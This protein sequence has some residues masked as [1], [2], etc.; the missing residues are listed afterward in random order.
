MFVHAKNYSQLPC[1][2]KA[3]YFNGACFIYRKS[4][5]KVCRELIPFV[6]PI[7]AI[8]VFSKP[9]RD[10][11]II[12]GK[13]KQAYFCGQPQTQTIAKNFSKTRIRKK[14]NDF[15]RHCFPS[16]K[17][18]LRK[19]CKK[20]ARKHNFCCK[21]T[22]INVSYYTN[23]LKGVL[24]MLSKKLIS[25]VL[26]TALTTGG[27]FAELYE[28]KTVYN[29]M[30]L[31]NG[32][33][34]EVSSSIVSGAGLRIL[35][36]L[37][38]VY[39]Y[40]NN[41]TA[42]ALNQLAESL[43][44]SFKGSK[45]V[46]VENIKRHVQGKHH[47]PK[48][49]WEDVT[50]QQKAE[51]LK[52]AYLACKQVDERIVRVVVTLADNTMNVQIT[53]SDCHQYTDTRSRGRLSVVAYAAEGDKLET[54]H[55]G[56]GAQCGIEYF[57]EVDVEETARQAG[58]KAIEMLKAEECPSGKMD[59]VIGNAFGGVIFHE[60]CGHSLEATS[61]SK[62]MSVFAGK[63]G[64]QIAS[65]VV[66]AVDDGTIENAWGSGNIDDEGNKTQK[67]VL[68]KNGILQ[69]YL[70]DKFNG[71][72][73]N[74]PA[75]GACRRQ[76]YK[77]EPTSRMSNTF[78]CNGKRTPEEII[79]KTKFGLYAKSMGG[80]SVNPVT[81]D[82]NFAVNEGYLIEDGKITKPVKGA[83][84]IGTGAEV[85][86]NIDMVGNDLKRAQGMCGSVSGTIPADVGQPTIR[87]RN[88][89]VGGRG[90]AIK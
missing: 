58:K 68:I 23:K 70:V 16:N 33:I 15:K 45:T 53:N 65:K 32:K 47:R 5:Q 20:Q 61:V 17:R 4:R 81:G 79:A 56:P 72:R 83:T 22:P 41:L 62:N 67:T 30:T 18:F 35:K 25:N 43:A 60:A 86:L 6:S 28:E 80:G 73:M 78:I 42:K 7:Q 69:N 13:Q 9:Q 52:K 63:L 26:N 38:S 19:I 87:V 27:D 77:F 29:N 40:T 90:G 31:D 11:H 51:L 1:A 84:L 59:V 36:Q 46:N 76:S 34:T 3:M 66:T 74:T 57:D 50:K 71:R 64:Q 48:I 24:I 54:F 49:K 2:I 82:F 14:D 75:N 55:E 37:Q 12:I 88:I 10:E 39:G 89:T 44:S 8:N 85:L 21:Y